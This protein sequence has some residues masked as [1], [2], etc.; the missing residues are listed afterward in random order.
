MQIYTLGFIKKTAEEFFTL[1][2][3]N[4][5]E[6]LLDIRTNKQTQLPGLTKGRDLEFFLNEICHC[7]YVY[8]PLFT[9]TKQLVEDYLEGKVTWSEYEEIFNE[10]MEER[11]IEQIFQEKY[12]HFNRICLL[13]NEQDPRNCHRRLVAE[14][15]QDKLQSEVE[16]IH[17]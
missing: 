3:E 13:C 15:L 5:I 7:Q 2:K 8:E 4:K 10:T 14:R 6:L 1:I 16:I 9:P 11:K 17:I 12:M